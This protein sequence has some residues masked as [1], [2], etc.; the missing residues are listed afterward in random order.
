MQFFQALEEPE[1]QVLEEH[2][3]HGEDI[4]QAIELFRQM[5]SNVNQ[6]NQLV[7]NMIVQVK[8]GQMST[9]NVRFFYLFIFILNYSLINIFSLINY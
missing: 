4:A 9:D 2:E 3:T 8:N 5:N 6:V 1:E 7:D